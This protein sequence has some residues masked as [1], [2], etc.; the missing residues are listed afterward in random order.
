MVLFCRRKCCS[1]KTIAFWML[2]PNNP[3]MTATCS[4]L[5]ANLNGPNEIA[6]TTKATCTLLYVTYFVAEGK[7]FAVVLP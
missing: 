3:A 1:L 7:W 6:K 5:I 2:W 4:A